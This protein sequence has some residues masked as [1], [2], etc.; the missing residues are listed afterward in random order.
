M[1]A[2]FDTGTWTGVTGAYYTGLGGAEMLWLVV[3]IGM[4][5]L[6]LYVGGKHEKESYDNSE[7]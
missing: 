6:A 2:P 5:L 1:G 7:N 4:C 3:S